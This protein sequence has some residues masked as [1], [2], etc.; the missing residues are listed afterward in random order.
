MSNAE[1]HEN[2]A[3]EHG[4]VV[5]EAS[6]LEDESSVEGENVFTVEKIISHKKE[7]GKYKFRIRWLKYKKEDDTWEPEENLIGD[8]CQRMLLQYKK[9]NGLFDEQ[10]DEEDIAKRK[11]HYEYVEEPLK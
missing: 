9:E 4:N 11:P 7:R 6:E 2:V 1:E 8:Y 10:E 3:E 5:Q